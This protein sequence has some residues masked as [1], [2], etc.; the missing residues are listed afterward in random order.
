[1]S[2]EEQLFDDFGEDQPAAQDDLFGDADED[3]KEEL[4]PEEQELQNEEPEQPAAGPSSTGGSLDR[5][6]MKATLLALAKKNTH[7]AEQNGS[8]KKKQKKDRDRD[9]S[10]S[11]SSSRPQRLKRQHASSPER[12]AAAGSRGGQQYEELPE[13]QL[14][15]ETAADLDFIDDDGVPEDER[16]EEDVEALAAAEEAEEAIPGEEEEG[17]PANIIEE[18][19]QRRKRAKRKESEAE[20]DAEVMSLVGMM[21]ACAESDDAALKSQPPRP[22]LEKLKQ[23]AEVGRV[24]RQ[25]KYHETFLASKG[26]NALASGRD[27]LPVTASVKL[28]QTW[29]VWGVELAEPQLFLT[30]LGFAEWAD[31]LAPLDTTNDYIRERLEE[32]ELGKIVMFYY[33]NPNESSE[34]Q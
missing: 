22:A 24:L 3:F 8:K 11:G 17:E 29:G 30:R 34:Y 33:K 25:R 12:G 7:A 31:Q 15:Q 10:G 32:S 9:K 13:E 14:A 20:V 28:L 27:M 26:L 16:Y 2:D 6:N 23:L 19:L 5:K 21:Q 18:V 4:E 1:M